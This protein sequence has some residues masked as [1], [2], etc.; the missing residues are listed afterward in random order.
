MSKTSFNE[1]EFQIKKPLHIEVKWRVWW[2]F[3]LVLED[4]VDIRVRRLFGFF[5]LLDV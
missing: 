3:S 1:E 5:D 4:P 2:V